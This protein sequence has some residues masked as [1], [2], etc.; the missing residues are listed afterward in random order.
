MDIEQAIKI[1]KRTTFFN[2]RSGTSDFYAAIDLA[3][4]ALQEKQERE[5]PCNA[6]RH[7]NTTQAVYKDNCMTCRRYYADQYESKEG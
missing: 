2:G 1:L 7:Y 4:K 3:T 5:N 6:C